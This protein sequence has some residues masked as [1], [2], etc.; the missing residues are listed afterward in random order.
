MQT[1][2][3]K[4]FPIVLFDRA[5]WSGLLDWMKE[6]LLEDGMVN[7][8]ELSLLRVMDDVDEVVS[9]V[10]RHVGPIKDGGGL[11]G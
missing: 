7:Q 1:K 5:Y 9:F 3:I 6:R 4:P 2:R 8:R 10:L 11:A